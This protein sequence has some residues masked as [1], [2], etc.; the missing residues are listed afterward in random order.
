MEHAWNWRNPERS[1]GSTLTAMTA[2]AGEHEEIAYGITGLPAD[3]TDPRHLAFYARR[4]WA[5]EN[6]ERYLRDVAFRY[7][8][9]CSPTAP[10]PLHGP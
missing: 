10:T 8:C 5:I 4:H 6:R 2:H 1:V 9:T 7:G 3:L